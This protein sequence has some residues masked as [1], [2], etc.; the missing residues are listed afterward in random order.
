MS[1]EAFVDLLAEQLQVAGVVVGSNYR[2]GYRAAGTAQLLQRLGPERGMQV[3]V[4]DLVGSAAAATAAPPPAD[5][6]REQ[7]QGRQQQQEQLE[8]PPQRQQDQQQRDK[9][10]QREQG[11]AQGAGVDRQEAQEA[12]SSS[13]V[14]HALA[15]GDMADA[16]MCLGRPH[17]LVASL[18]DAASSAEVDGGAAL[19][20]PSAALLN[21]PP[22]PGRYRVQAAM[23]GGDTLHQL[24]PSWQAL[25]A[26]DEAGLSLHSSS[27]IG[28]N[29]SGSSQLDPLQLPAGSQHLTLDFT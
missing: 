17:R 20:L 12:V 3:R 11:P 2:F 5:G 22:R 27:G 23:T 16:A 10:Q 25:L 26:I 28:G 21:Q 9:Q 7:Q 29:G 14:R 19:R 8:P 24:L 18:A 6:G 13:R 1:P 15:A 4:H